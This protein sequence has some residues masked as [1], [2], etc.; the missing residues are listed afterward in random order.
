MLFKKP[1][2]RLVTNIHNIVGSLIS[3]NRS[4]VVIGDQFVN[5]VITFL[6]LKGDLKS[7]IY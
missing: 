2:L 6:I 5:C 7:F 1:V 3:E 4:R